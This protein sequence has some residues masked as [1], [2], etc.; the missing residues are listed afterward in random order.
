MVRTTRHEM[1]RRQMVAIALGG[2]AA[3]AIG[4]GAACARQPSKVWKDVW[5]RALGGYDCVS[6]FSGGPPRK[7]KPAYEY[8]WKGARWWFADMSAM[9]AFVSKA[10]SYA[11]M[12]GGYCAQMLAEGRGLVGGDPNVWDFFEGRL[13]MFSS[14]RRR[15]DWR[16][17]PKASRAAAAKAWRAEFPPVA[18]L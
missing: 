10:P 8:L 14:A 13:V 16:V 9:E 12:C 5:G 4:A 17:D 11:P 18:S 1:T 15:E 6:Y 3:S 7:G 2:A